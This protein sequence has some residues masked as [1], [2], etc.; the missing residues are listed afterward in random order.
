MQL[1]INSAFSDSADFSRITEGE[2]QFKISA[3]VHKVF[4]KVDESGT[5]A[6]A[7][8]G[9]VLTA[10]SLFKPVPIVIKADHPFMYYISDCKNV[11]YFMGQFYG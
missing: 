6:A 10:H 4:I 3:V 2:S 11:V 5:E 9:A 7:A 8:T 1:G